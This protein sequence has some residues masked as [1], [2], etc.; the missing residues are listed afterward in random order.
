MKNHLFEAFCAAALVC[1]VAQAVPTPPPMAANGK[2][3]KDA[4]ARLAPGEVA[5]AMD[6]RFDA[7]PSKG[8]ATAL[9]GVAAEADGTLSVTFPAA[10]T[11][12]LGPLKSTF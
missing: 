3:P 2:V 5:L 8:S 7:L 12:L 1:V 4:A 6:V 10:P 9:F 11:S